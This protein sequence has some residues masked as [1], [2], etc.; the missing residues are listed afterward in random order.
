MA[1]S[2]NLKGLAVNQ[3]FDPVGHLLYVKEV[4]E[5]MAGFV[6]RHCPIC[7]YTG[8]FKAFGHPPRYDALCR[9]CGALE[10]HRLLHMAFEAEGIPAKGSRV[11]HFAPEQIIARL[12]RDRGVDYKSADIVPGRADLTLNLEALDLPDGGVDVAVANHV[13]EHVDDGKALAELHRVLAPGGALIVT[14]PI[15]EG[16]DQSYENETVTGPEDRE[17]H[18]GQWDHV[19]YYGRDLRRRM[20]AAGFKLKEFV[21]SGQDTVEYGLVRGERVFIGRKPA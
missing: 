12:L 16:W 20:E 5:R 11:I 19:R 3:Y 14:V 8:K 15:V 18:F 9:G 10:R 4:A 6:P 13:L 7:S 1:K 2:K 21:A 17:V